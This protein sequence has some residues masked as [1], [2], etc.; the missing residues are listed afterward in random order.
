[1]TSARGRARTAG[2][3][4][5][6]DGATVLVTGATGGIGQAIA[7]ACA[8][9]GAR[10]V[11]TGRRRDA[12]ERLAAQTGARALPSDLSRRADVERLAAECGPV[13]VLVANAAVPAGG[14]VLSLG[15]AAIDR[16]IDVNLRA[17][18]LLAR[19]LAEPMVVRGRGH[20]VFVSSLSGKAASPGGAIYAATKFGLRGFALGL[21]E[22]LRPA[23]VGVSLV[24]PGFISEAGMFADSGAPLPWY[25]ATRSPEQV[26]RAVLRAIEHNR[27][28]ID[29]A[30]L[31]LRLGAIAAGI[32]PGPVAAV[33]RRLGAA[34]VSARIAEG[35]AR[36][37]PEPERHQPSHDAERP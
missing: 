21:R 19:M 2:G 14:R 37:R 31:S 1:M 12:L 35:Q 23:G 25:V 20:L 13:D 16:A 27:A 18:M 15:T 33:Q 17:P 9:H 11:V 3:G 26:A 8:Q 36:A 29:V 24:F 32:A 4:L 34:T 5:A 10:L 7:A 30:P 28:E 6:L 22:D